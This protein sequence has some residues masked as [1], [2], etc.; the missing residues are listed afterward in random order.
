[1]PHGVPVQNLDTPAPR[2]GELEIVAAHRGVEELA[3]RVG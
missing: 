3:E 1:M 2:A